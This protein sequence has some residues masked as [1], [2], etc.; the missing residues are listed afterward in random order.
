MDLWSS[1][2]RRRTVFVIAT[3]REP[4]PATLGRSLPG[5]QAEARERSLVR[6]AQG[7]SRDAVEEL[8]R[9]HWPAA[10]RAAY[11]IVQDAAA[12]EDIAQEAF[13]AAL[14]ALD[15]F[16][17]RRPFAPW[18]HRIVANRA[19]D[20]SRARTARRE[21][22]AD[23][24]SVGGREESSRGRTACSRRLRRSHPS[25]A[26]SSCC[27]TCSG[28]RRDRSRS[29]S[30][31]HE[32]RSTRG[33]G[34]PSTGSRTSSERGREQA[35]RRARS[36]A[37]PRR[38]ARGRRGRA[39]LPNGRARRV[40]HPRAGARTAAPIGPA[41]RAGRRRG[42]GIA[43]VAVAS[44]GTE[45]IRQFVRDTVVA[46]KAA[47][48]PAA[49]M[50]LPGGGS[51]L[52]RAP[53]TSPSALWVVHGDGSRTLLGRYREGSWS[54]HAR[55]VVATAGRRLSALDPRTGT[56]RWS[57]TAAALG[58][59]SALVARADGTPVLSCRLPH[60][61]HAA[62]RC[63]RRL[64]RPP[65]R[66]RRPARGP[67]LA[68]RRPASCAGLRGPVRCGPPRLGRDRQGARDAV[69]PGLPT[70]VARLVVGRSSPARHEPGP[71]RGARRVAAP[72]R[73][74][75]PAGRRG[76]VLHRRLVR[77]SQ[78][79][80]DRAGPAGPSAR[81]RIELL[82]PGKP[83]RVL[84]TLVAGLTGL[85]PS[86]DG[87]SVL[88]GWRAAD[89]WLLVPTR[90]GG[91]ARRVTGLGAAFGSSAIPVA[92]AWA[93]VVHHSKGGWARLSPAHT[94]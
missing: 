27:D 22:T 80:P 36:R 88:V 28:T 35:R 25:T 52:V 57:I 16:D 93:S 53:E 14:R 62:H 65:A 3:Q 87:R 19:I 67:G 44:P 79:Q 81:T 55:F 29:C 39:A 82:R 71:A 47:T 76:R 12:A 77:A 61:R 91:R 8:Y 38:R 9:R 54:P 18:L 51:L 21:V 43:G 15:R 37:R 64:G 85:A 33:C 45:T 42:R 11:L 5:G 6:A 69:P 7:G 86:P 30:T 70:D 32:G 2:A 66:P 17:R 60:G 72:D 59:W 84:E 20:W 50:R 73:R 23:E 94:V 1:G 74:D 63:R 90:A 83:P 49:P 31:C 56:V 75:P 78:P 46:P 48:L 68:A 4:L 13:I 41:A 40:R 89:Q 10:H 26:R 92:N 24:A 34:V 58:A